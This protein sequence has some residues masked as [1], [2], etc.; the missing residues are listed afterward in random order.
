MIDKTLIGQDHRKAF[1][2]GAVMLL[3][4]SFS[5]IQ[6]A[7]INA[8][9]CKYSDVLSAYNSAKS[10][11]IV[12]VPSGSATWSNTLVI[13]KSVTLRGAGIGQTII[14]RGSP[15][16]S[17]TGAFLCVAKLPSDV[18]VTISGITFDSVRTDHVVDTRQVYI[19]NSTAQGATFDY[20]K[21]RITSCQFKNGERQVFWEGRCFGVVDHCQ[22]YD[23][24]ESGA[25]VRGD[26]DY[27]LARTDTQYGT[28]RAVV[29]EDDTF[30]EDNRL[31][32][33]EF[34]T[35]LDYAAIAVF[36]NCTFDFSGHT[37]PTDGPIGS[38]GNQ[39]YWQGVDQNYLGMM[40]CEIYKCTM[41]MAFGA[42]RFGY[43]RGGKLMFYNNTCSVVGGGSPVLIAMTEEE[44][45]GTGNKFTPGRLNWPAEMQIN[46]SFF[47]GNTI[48]GVAAGVSNFRIWD[49]QSATGVQLNRDYWLQAPG[50][51]TSTIYPNPKSPG[52]GNYPYSY[53]TNYRGP[54]TSYTPLVYPHPLVRQ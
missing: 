23:F 38:H 35:D 4:G 40:Q 50:P 39:G 33:V 44:Y 6:A 18:P 5:A 28:Q 36:R 34:A 41:K 8:A 48:N 51:A 26:G 19:L 15:T 9:S 2:I 29:F 43:V 1:L 7:T 54:V 11:D 13:S 31:S 21:I 24:R 17:F 46:N 53:Q 3:L 49:A 22:F 37:G 30:T 27:N 52:A 12:A 14:T 10:G 42:Y 47:W 25:H 16:A 20:T 32:R 45:N